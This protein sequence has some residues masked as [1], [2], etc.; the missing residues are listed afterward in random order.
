MTEDFPAIRRT[1]IGGRPRLAPGVY[2]DIPEAE[3]HADPF[4]QISLSSGVAKLLISQ[5]PRHAWTAHPRL[6]PEYVAPDRKQ[7]DLGS[8]AHAIL[9]DDRPE[10]VAVIDAADYRTKAAKEARAAAV[11]DGRLPLL[12]DQY[13]RTMEMVRA[14]RSQL[15]KN[16]D[17]KVFLEGGSSEITLGWMDHNVMCRARIDRLSADGTI[18]FDYKTT[19]ASAHPDA[20]RR[21]SISLQQSFQAAFYLRGFKECFP[22]M[23]PPQW[24]WIVQEDYP[25]Y[26]LSVLAPDAAALDIAYND[27]DLAL[28]IWRECIRDGDWP[29]Y[30]SVTATLET[31]PWEITRAETIKSKLGGRGA[32]DPQAIRDLIYN[33]QA[34]I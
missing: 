23:P 28:S 12:E 5:S 6:N 2:T 34:P 10:R 13:G 3:Y 20:Y 9:L 27:V 8:A 22:C 4:A 30:P 19:A 15:A 18:I 29:C 16:N 11:E 21:T 31:P 17:G 14:A 1:G 32:H 25:P 26:A 7:F 24:R 33:W